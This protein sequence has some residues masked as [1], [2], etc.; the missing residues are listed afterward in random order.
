MRGRPL[1]AAAVGVLWAAGLAALAPRVLG[2]QASAPLLT[3]RQQF[4]VGHFAVAA[5]TLQNAIP[6]DPNDAALYY[7]LG[8]CYFELNNFDQAAAQE[9]RAVKLDGRNSEYHQWLGRA[10][11]QQADAHHSLWLGVKTRNEF[12]EAVDLDPKNIEARRNLAEFYT[13]APWI[14]GGSKGKARQQIAAIAALNPVQGALAQAEYDR[15]T[16]DVAGALAE[17]QQVLQRDSPTMNEYV[18][19]ADYYARRG[20]AATLQR[21]ITGMA[22]VAPSDSRLP[23]YRGVALT[24][25]GK[26]LGEAESYL[27]AYLATTVDRSDYPL[28]ANA[29]TWLGHVYEELG[30]KLEA[31]EQYRAALGIDPNSSFAKDSLKQLEKQMH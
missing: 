23:Y 27:K 16:G 25:E 30:R 17:Y 5:A 2:G 6:S 9:E 28:H 10:Y 8:R 7:W 22:G 14:V 29:R 4:Q 31:A 13:D 19:I 24:I 3:A 15:E 12:A 26:Q 20:D 21:I 11:G 18:E 1:R